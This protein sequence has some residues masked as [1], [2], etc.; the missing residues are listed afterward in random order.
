MS[1][2]GDSE[3]SGNPAIELT[4]VLAKLDRQWK[5]QQAAKPTS[6]WTKIVFDDDATSTEEEPFDAAA[7]PPPGAA[8]AAAAASAAATQDFVY[9]L[10]PPNN[11]V[12]SCV[13]VFI[14]GAGLGQFPQ[15][16]YKEFLTRTSDRLNAAV[17]TAP[18]S[19]GLDHFAL[20]KKTGELSRRAVEHCQ[21]D[22]ARMHPV[23]LPVYCVTHSLGGKLA[24]IHMAATQQEYAGVGMMS[25]NNFG[26]SK[27]IGMAR[28]FAEQIRKNTTGGKKDDPFAQVGGQSGSEILNQ[29][30]NFA[31]TIVG[32]IGLDFSPS[33]DAMNKLIG[34]KYDEG[35]QANTRMFVF[36]EDTLDSTEDFTSNCQGLGPEVSELKGTHLTP[37]YFKFGL[38]ELELPEQ[39][40][41]MASDAMGGIDSASFGNEEE[42]NAVVNEVCDWIL[43]KKPSRRAEQPRLTGKA[44]GN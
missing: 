10:E 23:N 24:T 8:A 41:G 1:S 25:F 5:I 15:I 35:R 19:V 2:N 13:I 3:S 43:G 32:T 44:S 26:F 39:A 20:A 36:D 9:L 31:E 6:R 30:F 4:S 12:P 17:I 37:V 38:D 29:V 28:E 33:P 42:L 21:E 14:G 11:S 16:A 18:Y 40:R 7:I 27:T 34:M 22:S